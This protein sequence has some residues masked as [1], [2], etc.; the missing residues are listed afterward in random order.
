MGCIQSLSKIKQGVVEF[1]AEHI[2]KINKRQI[3]FLKWFSK[4][5]QLNALSCPYTTYCLLL[6]TMHV[7]VL[8]ETKYDKCTTPLQW[9]K[10]RTWLLATARYR[11]KALAFAD[12]VM[13]SSAGKGSISYYDFINTWDAYRDCEGGPELDKKL[14]ALGVT[15]WAKRIK[16]LSPLIKKEATF[17]AT[18]SVK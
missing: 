15:K 8:D 6:A 9:D 11:A 13:S 5:D 18:C 17:V 7:M 2:T 16:E 4:K 3:D 14:V 10:I 1:M 12:V